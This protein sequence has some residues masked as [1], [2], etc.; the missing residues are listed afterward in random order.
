MNE[1]EESREEGYDKREETFLA[2]VR[3]GKSPIF[4]FR[5]ECKTS[6]IEPDETGNQDWKARQ[7]ISDHSNKR[8]HLPPNPSKHFIPSFTPPVTTITPHELLTNSNSFL[9]QRTPRG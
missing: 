3:A 1:I 4:Y 6:R 7:Y 9:S 8:T 2:W 5:G